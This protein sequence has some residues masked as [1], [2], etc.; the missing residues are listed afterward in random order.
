MGSAC[1]GEHMPTVEFKAG[2]LTIRAQVVEESI[3]KSLHSGKD[4]FQFEVEFRADEDEQDDINAAQNA[5]GPVLLR[6]GEQPEEVPIT[7]QQRMHSFTV[8]RREQIYKWTLTEM[9]NLELESLQLGDIVLKPYKFEE[10]VQNGL[11]HIEARVEIDPSTREQLSVLPTYFPVVRMGISN[12]PLSMRF[13]QPL[14]SETSSENTKH[15]Y[16]LVEERYDSEKH[17]GFLEPQFGN[18]RD[19]LVVTK[20]QLAKLLD[21][22]GA[23]GLLTAEEATSVIEVEESALRTQHRLINRVDDIDEWL[24]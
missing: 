4:L 14:W 6:G 13:G 10:E 15:R 21:V 7:I 23:K 11:I 8:G 18:V 16:V 12:E 19:S 20:A 1:E 5:P 24:D 22:L 3:N 17:Q 9:E 2:D